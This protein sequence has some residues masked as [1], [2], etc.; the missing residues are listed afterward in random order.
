[1]SDLESGKPPLTTRLRVGIGAAIVLVIVALVCSVLVTALSPVGASTVVAAGAAAGS[2][3]APGG[4]TRSGAADAGGAD[5]GVGDAPAASGAPGAVVL[6]HVLGAVAHP[7]LY[8]LATGARVFDGIAAAGGFAENA[9]QGALNLARP[10]TDG[11]QVRVLAVGEAPPVV[12]AAGSGAGAGGGQGASVAAPGAPGA[13]GAKVDLNSATAIDLDT[14]PRIGP[15]MAD[16]IIAW[17]TD[18]GPFTA[19]EDLMQITG[20]GEKTFDGLRDLVTV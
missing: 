15:A 6:V 18:N 13:S 9:D 8:E 4:A 10:L 20:I 12:S 11:E 7:G 5:Q 3:G 1:M 16:R 14:L 17:R 2:P 19:V